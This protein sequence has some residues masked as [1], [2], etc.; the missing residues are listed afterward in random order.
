MNEPTAAALAYGLDQKN[1]GTVA[2]YDFGGGTFDVSILKME[3][4]IFEVKATGGDT[5]LGGDDID[6]ARRGVAARERRRSARR[7]RAT[8]RRSRAAPRRRPS[9]GSRTADATEVA[10][11]LP[12]G[13]RLAR[14]AHPRRA[15]SS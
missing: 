4:G 12:D 15:S 7:D 3:R 9:A 6:E 1:E 5:R 14:D 8:C 11:T 2:V 10:V 13:T